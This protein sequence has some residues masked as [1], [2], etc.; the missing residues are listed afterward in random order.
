MSHI[1]FEEE[2]RLT[3]VRWI[4]FAWIAFLL[5]PLFTLPLGESGSMQDVGQIFLTMGATALPLGVV[6]FMT[7]FQVKIDEEG[8][9]YRFMPNSYKWRFIPK[10]TIESFEVQEKKTW[11]EKIHCGYYRSHKC[12]SIQMNITGKKLVHVKLTGGK[13]IKIGSENPEGIEYAL[14]RLT[15]AKDL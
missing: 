11:F 10:T 12:N 1:H 14:K 3:R 15:T 13:R 6:L 8:I 2:Q 7:R 4:W 5:F 9:R